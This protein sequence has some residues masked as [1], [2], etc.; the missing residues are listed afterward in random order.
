VESIVNQAPE[1]NRPQVR[2]ILK[3]LFPPVEWVFGGSSYGS[4]FEEKWFRGLRVCHP[5]VFD[6]YFHLTIPE[7]DIS[8]SDLDL[9]LS[10]VGDRE[11]LVTEFRAL[12]ERGL[13][14]IALDRLEH[15]KEEIELQH[16]V[17]FITA[18]FDIGDELPDKSVGLFSID[19]DVHASRIIR[20]Y[21]KREKD[22]G[23][24]VEILKET[25]KATTGLY[26]PVRQTCI[27]DSK[28]DRQ[29]DPE[30]FI[31]AEDDLKDLENICVDKIKQAA[32]SGTLKINSHMAYILYRWREWASLEEPRKWVEGL[33][34]S[35]EGLLCFL[36]AFLQRST[37]QGMEDYVLRIHW[38]INLKSVEDFVSAEVLARKIEQL[39]LEDLIDEQQKA[40][41]AFQKAL[42]RRQEGKSDGDWRDDEYD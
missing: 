36:T 9:I 1:T 25:M 7:G 20:W 22:L 13:L 6:R 2:E 41:R 40:V 39:P 37:S 33:I 19:P 28:E 27:E 38:R 5:N 4:G 11:G 42:K 16:A 23:K 10:L 17:P 24:R 18:L 26:L 31:V 12:N 14:E 35:K 29:K 3:Q 32:E 21:L 15:Y 30:A 8:Q 34:E